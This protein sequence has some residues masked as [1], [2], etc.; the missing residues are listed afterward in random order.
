MTALFISEKY[1]KDNVPVNMNVDIEELYK[2]TKTAEDLLIQE[3][4]GTKLYDYLKGVVSNAKA[5]PPIAISTNDRTLLEH[6][7]DAVM[8]YTLF[9]AL[10]F[11]RT[12]IRNIGVVKQSGENLETSDKGDYA[13]LMDKC[14]GKGDFYINTV[15][16]YLCKYS[17]L[18]AEYKCDSWNLNPNLLNVNNSGFGFAKKEFKNELKWFKK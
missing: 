4:I 2:F 1:L 11:L 12:K 5:S 13:Q 16:K 3:V 15:K 6:I 10:P 14:K 18:Y 7:R 17:K 9:E 8:W